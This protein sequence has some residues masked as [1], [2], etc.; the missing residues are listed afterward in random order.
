M[1][2]IKIDLKKISKE[3]IDLIVDY[4]KRGQII[5]YPT[6]TVYGLGCLAIK[7]KA[8]KQVHKIK[9]S[10]ADKPLLILIKSYCQLHDICYVSAKQDRYI[11]S[12]WPRTTRQAQNPEYMHNE[13]PTT[14]ILRGKGV[15][16]GIIS[17]NKDSLAVRLP[18]ANTSQNLPKKQFL[19]KILKK[20]N[21]PLISTSLN[22]YGQKPLAGFSR[23]EKYFFPHTLDLL[24]DAGPLTKKAVSRII[25]IRDINN[26]KTLRN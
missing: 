18:V 26:I 19:I 3:E 1:K 17:G 14:F 9:R 4:L 11:R 15:L 8:I 23:I 2:K 7:T 24:I 22:K 20:I 5:A 21:T 13:Q 10:P 16:P 12:I 6:E 25:D